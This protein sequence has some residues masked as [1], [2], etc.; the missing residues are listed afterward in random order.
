MRL[1]SKVTVA[2]GLVTLVA[3]LCLGASV[4]LSG[5]NSGL[6]QINLRLSQV[7]REIDSTQDDKLSTA[8]LLVDSQEIGLSYLQNDGQ[9]TVLKSL[10]ATPGSLVEKSFDLGGGEKL[11]FTISNSSVRDATIAAAFQSLILSLVATVLTT[12]ITYLIL[13][14]DIAAL[15]T[16]VES[17]K[18]EMQSF[19]SDASHELRTPLTVIRGYLELLQ[20][21]KEM[22]LEKKKNALS[23]AH[24]EALRMQLLINDILSLAELGQIPKTSFEALNI[25]DLIEAQIND[26]QLLEPDRPIEVEFESSLYVQGSRQLIIQLAANI[27]GNIRNH[28]PANSKVKVAILRSANF[29]LVQVD[30]SG[31]GIKNLDSN[32]VLTEFRRFDANRSRT[33]GGS[34]L[35]LSIMSRI[36]KLHD[37]KLELTKSNLGGLSVCVRLPITKES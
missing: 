23:R 17:S 26:F 15:V 35:G 2:T 12:L 33:A 25:T 13:K 21:P 32:E 34:G 11:V 28:T 7:V 22:P 8:L 9:A 10:D 36:A 16:Q 4:L 1:I 27:F 5:Y 3:T 14:R 6:H 30:D 20:S 19:L 18:D 24:S 31:P 29:V 37:G